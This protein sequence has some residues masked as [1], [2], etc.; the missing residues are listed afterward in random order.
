MADQTLQYHMAGLK[1]FGQGK[2]EDALL[3]YAKA[4]EQAPDSPEVLNAVAISQS[5][6]GR[7]DE[8]IATIQRVIAITPEDPFAYTSLSIFLQRQGK[9]PEAE[10]AGAKARMLNWKQELKKNPNAPPPDNDGKMRVIQ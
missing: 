5:K 10:S 6:L 8:A 9:I 3:E 1:L 2:F 4:L 7:H